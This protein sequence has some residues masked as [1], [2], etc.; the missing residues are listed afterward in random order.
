MA[1]RNT[2]SDAQALKERFEKNHPIL[3]FS[4]D[5]SQGETEMY[6]G[7]IE[8]QGL[9]DDVIRWEINEAGKNVPI[10]RW[11]RYEVSEVVI[12]PE[13]NKEWHNNDIGQQLLCP[14]C[15]S[16]FVKDRDPRSDAQVRADTATR[17]AASEARE[18]W[19]Q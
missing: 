19:Y 14:S 18:D 5:H 9:Q 17:L 12:C 4:I 10:V 8:A 3:T 13:C 1:S 11:Q 6:P 15:I 16:A 7:A 2:L